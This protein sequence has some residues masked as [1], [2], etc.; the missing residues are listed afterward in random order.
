MRTLQ[1]SLLLII[2]PLF[3]LASVVVAQSGRRAPRATTPSASKNSALRGP[4]DKKSIKEPA[5][6]V[7]LLVAQE[8]TAKHFLS[9]DAIAASFVKRLNEHTGITSTW[10][11]E[12]K[13]DQAVKRAQ[14]E[15]EVFVILLQ[16]D[17]DRVQ[18]G[19]IV[20]NS[21][22]LQLKYLVFAPHTGEQKLKGKVYYQAIG[23]AKLRKDNWPN[24]PAI[25]ITPEATGIEAAERVF[26]WLAVI[27]GIKSNQ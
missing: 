13:R 2:V 1:A 6:R 5:A 17:I 10:I 11:G 14:N 20:L 21:P 16:F 22:D 12:L 4:D 9:E 23:G 24:G 15:T 7:N 18:E 8:N 19:K 3:L 26:Q 25:K 27:A